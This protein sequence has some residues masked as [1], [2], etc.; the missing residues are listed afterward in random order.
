[1][2]KH[3]LTLLL[4][5]L[6]SCIPA[7]SQDARL[8]TVK[9]I[10]AERLNMNYPDRRRPF[11]PEELGTSFRIVDIATRKPVTTKIKT[12]RIYYFA[13]RGDD[14]VGMYLLLDKYGNTS[15]LANETFRE[16]NVTMDFLVD[17]HYKSKALVRSFEFILQQYELDRAMT[18]QETDMALED[19]FAQRIL[20]RQ[21]GGKCRRRRAKTLLL[22]QD[23]PGIQR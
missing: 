6:C 22:P 20:R 9:R 14:M 17:N 4:A 12:G 1:M 13:P 10:V 8:E 11:V 7:F 16:L 15:V 5:T 2:K 3:L 18:V 19:I 21:L 23:F